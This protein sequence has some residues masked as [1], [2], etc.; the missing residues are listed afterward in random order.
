MIDEVR[1]S[2]SQEER[3]RAARDQ[4]TRY[5]GVLEPMM[6]QALKAPIEGDG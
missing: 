2:K 3:R 1:R 4:C 6:Q 5:S